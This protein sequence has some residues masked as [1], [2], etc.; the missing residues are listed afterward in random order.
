ML[1]RVMRLLQLLTLLCLK[2]QLNNWY[3]KESIK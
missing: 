2:L 3:S 1:I